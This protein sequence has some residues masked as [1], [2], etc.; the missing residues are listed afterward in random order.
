MAIELGSGWRADLDRGPEW[1]FVRLHSCPES[2][3]NAN[4]AGAIWELLETEFTKRVVLELDELPVLP[5]HLIGEIV[6][7]HKRVQSRGGMM[8]LCG[9]SDANQEVLR[10]NRLAERFPQYRTRYE[11]VM[12]GYRP[13]QPR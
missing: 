11:A 6:R 9:L 12:G 4:L 2:L 13:R 3:N 5:S 1:L 10:I 8:R 7:L